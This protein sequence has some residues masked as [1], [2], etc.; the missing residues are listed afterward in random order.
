MKI[1][2]WFKNLLKSKAEKQREEQEAL[3]A[4]A[5]AEHARLQAAKKRHPAGKAVPVVEKTTAPKKK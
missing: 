4:K 1:Q 5:V 3:K 2:N